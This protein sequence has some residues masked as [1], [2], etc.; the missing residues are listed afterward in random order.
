MRDQCKANTIVRIAIVSV[1]FIGIVL[2][3]P[4]GMSQ[5]REVETV[6]HSNPTSFQST[7]LKTI[8][9]GDYYPYTFVNDKGIPDGFSVDIAKAVASVMGLKL[10]ISVDTWEHAIKALADGTI[11]FLPMMAYSPEREKTFD[12]SAPHTIAYDAVFLRSGAQ[13]I[14]SLK[15]LA[16]K[17]VIV[18]NKDAAHQY[19]LSS[20]MAVKMKL[21]LVD[22]LQDAL[23]SLAAGKGDAALM[24]KLV[25][26]ITIKNLNLTNIDPSPLFI[27]AYNRQ[28]CFAVKEGNQAL[29]ERL[30]QGLS[31]AKSTGRYQEIYNKWF[32]ALEPP[33]LPWETVIKYVGAI[34]LVFLLIGLGMLLWNLTLRKQVALQTK[35]LVAEIK[36][37]KRAE[38]ALLESEAKHLA[39][40]E[41]GTDAIFWVDVHTEIIINCN[42]AAENMIGVPCEK[43]IGQNRAILHPA[44]GKE[45][46]A[47]HF[48]RHTERG[49]SEESEAEVISISGQR[50]PVMISAT[51]FKIGNKEIIQG[52]F[53]DISNL[54]QAEKALRESE[55]RYRT[56]VDNASDI[57]FRTD[58]TGCFTF[59]NP[60]AL[61]ITGYE[62]KELIGKQ[63]TTLIHPDM[64]DETI[65]FFSRQFVKGIQNTYIEYPILT[66]EGREVWIGQ[67]TQLITGD[68][69]VVGFQAMARDIMD[70]KRMEAE[71]FALS[72]TDQLTGLHNRRGF[73]SLAGQQ[74][75]LAERNKNGMLLFFADLDGLKWIN[76]TLG[77]EE[78]DRALTEAATVLKETFRTS[79]IIA[80]MGGDEFAALAVDITAASS[81]IFTDRLQSLVETRN[82]QENR[83][84]RLS[85][86]VGCSYYDP[87]HPCSIDELTASADKLMYEQKQN[88]KSLLLQGDSLSN[89]NC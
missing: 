1:L 16:G 40:F 48:R 41:L 67:S 59:V 19:L 22:S 84:Y 52:I 49:S 60:A 45:F 44:E 32:G 13:R 46:Y 29:L 88:K 7:S 6:Q 79:D 86:S 71:I 64:R 54:K 70:R 58:D 65:K 69:H 25:G 80:R 89:S 62:E 34:V 5:A 36:E 38:E 76:D 81:A 10:E 87:E 30:S 37:H 47:G 14:S 55:E 26:L 23:R 2:I 63:Y 39:A 24:P 61:R 9:V 18:L 43:L 78:G 3:F 74:L 31:I 82:N 21:L 15:D 53:R 20:G 56:L 75:K 57:I 68:G 42:R 85:I 17:T 33:G 35:A 66:K 50:I 73:L 4:P 8:I 11:D 83:K 51:L 77:H 72:I 12:F 28:F 27:D